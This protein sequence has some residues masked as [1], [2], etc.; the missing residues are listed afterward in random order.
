MPPYLQ[1]IKKNLLS[2]IESRLFP[3]FGVSISAALLAHKNIHDLPEFAY[4]LAVYSVVSTVFSMPLASIG[5]IFHLHRDKLT[6]Q[7]IFEE[8]FKISI[9]FS[10]CAFFVAILVYFS[11][12]GAGL[13][14][15]GENFFL[16]SAIYIPAIPLLVLNTYLHIFHESTGAS[17]ICAKIKRW[18]ILS[19]CAVLGLAFFI[20]KDKFFSYFAIGYF[21]LVEILILVSLALLSKRQGY[22]FE[23]NKKSAI[24]NDVVSL[25]FP[26]AA[27][28]A[29]QKLYYYLLNEKLLSLDS[30]LAGHLS[31][32][33]SV[34]GLLSIPLVAFSQMHSVYTS[35]NIATENNLYLKG[36]VTCTALIL[37][38]SIFLLI[39]GKPLFYVFGDNSLEFSEKAFLVISFSMASSG[40]F[41]VTTSHLRA[42]SDTLTP[43][44]I[45]NL[46][47]LFILI[48]I[49]YFT[50]IDNVS[51]YI[52]ISLQAFAVVSVTLI[53]Q[54]RIFSLNKKF[55]ANSFVADSG[56]R[57]Q[58]NRKC[59]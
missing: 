52:F 31:I 6:P 11:L 16:L 8:G 39:G 25:G 58:R 37:L 51:V 22:V 21:S 54:L 28:L 43:Q 14:I 29:G 15:D 48:P 32:C 56:V 3:F 4:T 41:M 27:G 17:Y 30:S 49:I 18:S 1:N 38:V 53:L 45:I 20:S 47:M 50:S 9:V 7:A 42:M 5:N 44:I 23:A 36:I 33:M 57:E 13:K 55:I 35:K 2:F 12:A 26:I 19:G 10:V 34:I 24:L 59:T 46:V 40:F